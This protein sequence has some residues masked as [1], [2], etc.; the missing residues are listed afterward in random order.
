VDD[1]PVIREGIKAIISA[2]PGF[3]VVGEASSA[4]EAVKKAK[5][6]RPDLVVADVSLPDKSG[7]Q[8]TQNL[9]GLFPDLRVVMLSMHSKI[10]YIAQAF[11][12]GAKAYV[13]KAS[14]AGK[15][16][17][18]LEAVASGE[19][20]LDGSVSGAVIQ[21]LVELPDPERRSGDDAYA[22]L[23]PREQEVMRLLAEGL[24]AKQIADKLFISPKT[25]E[26]H[27]ANLMGKLNVHTTLDLVRYAARLGLI[28]LDLWKD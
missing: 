14:A 25:V 28:D 17:Q 21:R 18:A 22:N 3:E 8:L 24:S 15:L 7:I 23:T 19:N 10:E 27:R 2:S 4:A 1:H 11:Q 16:I 13:V 26:N 20:Y 6:I 12:A 9:T 5:Q